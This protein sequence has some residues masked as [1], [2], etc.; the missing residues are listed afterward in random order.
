LMPDGS[1][2][3]GTGNDKI[4]IGNSSGWPI[5]LAP[6]NDLLGVAITEGIEN[7]LSVYAA[8]GLGV[9]AAGSASRMPALANAIPEWIDCV[10]VVADDDA[11]GRKFAAELAARML[12]RNIEARLIVPGAAP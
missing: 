5:I 2:K 3:A 8:T 12:S 1:N 9:W 7:G 11:D 4:M 6:P 10:T